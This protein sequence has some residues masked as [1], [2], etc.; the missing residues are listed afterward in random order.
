[1]PTAVHVLGNDPATW[2]G[3]LSEAAAV[4]AAGGTVAFPTETVYGLGAHALDP[5]AVARIYAAKGRPA[6]NP[7]IVHVVDIAQA[8][9]LA[10]DWPETADSLARALW[11]GPLTLI[12]PK[13]DCVPPIVTAGGRTVALRMPSHPVARALLKEAGIPVAAPS[14][15]VS[16]SI[17]ST[18]AAHV[19]KGLDGKIDMLL[20]G[21]TTP[22]GLESTVVDCSVEPPVIRRHGLLSPAD[23]AA[24]GVKDAPGVLHAADGP[25]V[26]PGMRRRHY[27]PA[28]PLVVVSSLAEGLR[29][30]DG[31]LT[32]RTEQCAAIVETLPDDARGY[33]AG[34]YGALHRLEDAGV[35]RIVVVEPPRAPG[36]EAV[37]DRLRRASER[38]D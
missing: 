14:A 33:G 22:G 1:M 19:L 38:P 25:A 28:V 23:L 27:A 13:A 18:T 16:E 21:G 20:D 2:S 29:E 10:G 15:N 4:L 32:F 7:I 9:Q 17:S 6:T 31:L 11:P 36:W 34:L 12:V 3:P 30:N 24:Y 35:E 37:H 5:D 26:S 8:K